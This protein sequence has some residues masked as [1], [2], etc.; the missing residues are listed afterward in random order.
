MAS[1]LPSSSRVGPSPQPRTSSRAQH[2]PPMSNRKPVV[3]I[4]DDVQDARDIYAA[5]LEAK[6]FRAI[7]AHDGE[8]A[9]GLTVSLRPDVV[10]MDLAMPRL[11]GVAATRRLKNDPRTQRI[12]IILLTGYAERAIRD[13]ALEAGVTVFLTKPCLPEDLEAA[14]RRLIPRPDPPDRPTDRS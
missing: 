9:V 6:G 10:V 2:A 14:V 1:P 13:G 7:K 11:D 12:P 8:E 3:L 5:C 4:A